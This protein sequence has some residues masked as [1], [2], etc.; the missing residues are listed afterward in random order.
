MTTSEVTARKVMPKSSVPEVTSSKMPS[1]NL[2]P[3]VTSSGMTPK[4]HCGGGHLQITWSLRSPPV[5]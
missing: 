3:E 5:R 4:G 1:R 2:V